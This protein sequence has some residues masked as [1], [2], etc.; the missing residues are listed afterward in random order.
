MALTGDQQ[1]QLQQALISKGGYNSADAANAARNAGGR[2]EDLYREFVGGGPATANNSV[3]PS[4]EAAIA[5]QQAGIDAS[6]QALRGQQNLLGQQTQQR[7]TTLKQQ[8][9]SLEDRYNNLIADIKATGEQAV[10]QQQN[11]TSEELARRGISLQGNLG[12]QQIQNAV[13][14]VQGE[15][16]RRLTE[17]GTSRE[18]DLMTIAQAISQL[19]LDEQTQ[20]L[21]IEQ[22]IG[23]LQAGGGQAAV[24]A[25]L[26]MLQE[27]RAQQQFQ[28]TLDQ[29]NLQNQYA[30]QLFPIQL[31]TQQAQLD[32]L[33]QSNT[34]SSVN[35]PTLDSIFSGGDVG[36]SSGQYTFG[37]ET[38]TDNFLN[39]VIWG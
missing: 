37:D 32:K 20:R 3:N 7:Q 26:Q 33:L 2:A 12:Q 10:K 29:Q 21:A 25:A 15:L 18:Q 35:R 19:P 16:N 36:G 9:S 23:Q 38:V 27:N 22:A 14:P 8:Q 34:Q 30:S 39:N 17:V 4:V 1:S 11:I 31:A 5:R 24:N 6:V 28:S 13:S